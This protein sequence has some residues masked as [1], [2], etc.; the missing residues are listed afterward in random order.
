M[1]WHGRVGRAM[2]KTSVYS[3]SLG[4]SICAAGELAL[5]SKESLLYGGYLRKRDDREVEL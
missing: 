1:F 2:R 4:K 3:T 5:E